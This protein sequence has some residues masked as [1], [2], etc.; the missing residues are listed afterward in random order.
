MSHDLL[1]ILQIRTPL[2]WIVLQLEP[3]LCDPIGWNLP[4]NSHSLWMY[5]N[6]SLWSVTVGYRYF[7]LIIIIKGEYN[8]PVKV[9]IEY[10]WPWMMGCLLLSATVSTALCPTDS[11]IL[12]SV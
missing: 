10:G 1:S 4:T 9:W 2:N 7:K 3:S 5:I 12:P 8:K 6:K 11:T